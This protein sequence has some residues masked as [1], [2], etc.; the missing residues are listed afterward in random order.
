MIGGFYKISETIES[1]VLS[2]KE[3]NELLEKLE[4]YDRINK[5]HGILIEQLKSQMENSVGRSE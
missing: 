1:V 4:E 5:E 3:Y 2:T